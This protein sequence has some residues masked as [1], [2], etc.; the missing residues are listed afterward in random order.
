MSKRWLAVL[1]LCS[2][3][4]LPQDKPQPAA[5]SRSFQTLTAG[6]QKLDGFFPLYWDSRAGKMWLEIDRF[7]REFLYIADLSAG[8]GSNDLGL[9]RGRVGEPRVVSF[10]R[11]GPKVLLIQSN[12]QF[13]ATA[14][15]PA[16][17]TAV[18]DSFARSALWGF[19]VAAEDGSRVLVDATDFFLR[20]AADVAQDLRRQ[21]QGDYR[22]DEKRSA[23]YL[24]LTKNF[25][26]NT[27]IETTLTLTGEPSGEFIREV[28]PTPGAITIR[29]HQ[30]LVELPPPGYRP[31]SQDP[32]AGYFSVDFMDFSAPIG[33]PVTRRFVVR[34]RLEKKDP[35]APLSDPVSPIVYYVDPAA[36]QSVR[37]ALIE[38][39]SWWNQAFEAAGFRNAFQ[40]RVLPPD[41]DPMDVRYN[42]IQWV[43]RATRGWSL[44]AAIA[45]PR[46]GEIIKGAVILGSLREH[47]DYLIFEGLMAPHVPGHDES[48]ALEDAVY[49]RLRQLAA[50]EV[51]H[52]LGLAHN[53]IASTHDRASVMDYPGPWIG[54]RPDNTFDLSKAYAKGIG[55]WDKVAIRWGYSQFAPGADEHAELDRILSTAAQRGLIFIT[56]ADSRPGDSAHPRA[57][58]WDNG[59]NAVDE[60]DR[61]MK[62]RGIAL[63]RFG[64]NN[65]PAGAPMATLD[66]VLVPLYFLHRYQTEAASKVLG[67]N[68]YT[69]ALRGDGQPI[70]RIVPAAEQRRALQALLETIDPANLTIPERILNLIPPR[71]PGYPRTR[72]TFPS[73]TGVTFDPLAAAEA[74]ANLTISLILNSERAARLVQYHAEDA[75]NPGLRDTIDVLLAATWQK[76]DGAGLSGEVARIVRRTVLVQLLALAADNS[77]ASEVRNIAISE[78]A[79]VKTAL[80]THPDAYCQQ[81][82][83]A[84]ER[85]PKQLAL[86]KLADPPPGQPIG[87]DEDWSPRYLEKR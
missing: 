67:G 14:A 48:G 41:A 83:Q 33:Q 60:L 39:A 36:P 12:Y 17:Q 72:E 18:R 35:A 49:G 8:V 26:K 32:R 86:P 37:N 50:H 10:E 69:Y 20:D 55:E 82:I 13:R 2:T 23:F 87:D 19:Q 84:F 64:E 11:S 40:V 4:A 1:V 22:P 73:N 15:D 21:K 58:L 3:P 34:H 53:F 54:L 5:E 79:S 61:M 57:H 59:P 45:D 27:E 42:V 71:P 78:V 46:T 68:E 85:D 28:A 51:G 29:E 47:Q 43:H 38:G 16:Q 30:S 31:R 44:G 75:T 70:T 80:A 7:D 65:I 25:P 24:A 56:D 74:G 62:I 77:A 76:P 52:T 63:S 66:E 6:L 81:L 9:D